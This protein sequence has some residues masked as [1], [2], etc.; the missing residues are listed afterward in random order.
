MGAGWCSRV[1]QGPGSPPRAGGA[2]WAAEGLPHTS[3]TCHPGRSELAF[4]ARQALVSAALQ[5]EMHLSADHCDLGVGWPPRTRCW[6]DGLCLRDPSAEGVEIR[7]T[8]EVQREVP[9]RGGGLAGRRG[10]QGGCGRTVY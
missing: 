5:G 4:P 6:S 10:I 9:G 3:F 8:G 1:R 7:L 2:G